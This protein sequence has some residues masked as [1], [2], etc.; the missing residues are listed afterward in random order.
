MQNEFCEWL[1]TREHANCIIVAYQNFQA[2][3]GF[4]I[5]YL[6]ENGIPE[7]IMHG[8]KILTLNVLM[9][10]IKFIHSLSFIPARLADFP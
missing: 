3:D 6:H 2:N 9:F 7:V 8:A 4:F 5:E 1:F 10:K